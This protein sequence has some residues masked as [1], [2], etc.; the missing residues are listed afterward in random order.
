MPT[1]TYQTA[2]IN[3]FKVTETTEKGDVRFME[4]DG[5]KVQPTNR[6]WTSLCSNFSTMGM[7]LKMFKMFSHSEVFERLALRNGD[8]IQYTMQGDG[9]GANKLLGICKPGKPLANY[10]NVM[11][12]L[13]KYNASEIEYQNGSGSADCGIVQSWHTPRHMQDIKVGGDTLVPKYVL[14]T[15]IDGFGKP[16]I[17]LSLLR[18]VCTNGMIGYSKAFKS[19]LVLGRGQDVMHTLERALDSY[20]NEEG[21]M[22]LKARLESAT[23]S[24]ASVGE[25]QAVFKTVSRMA[26]DFEQQGEGSTWINDLAAREGIT[27]GGD[28]SAVTDGMSLKLQRALTR[29]VGDF[30]IL[31]GLAHTDALSQRQQQSM[32][33]KATVYDLLNFTT[34]AATHYCEKGK[35]KSLH[36]IVG[37]MLTGEYDLEESKREVPTF[38]DWHIADSNEAK[39]FRDDR[40]ELLNN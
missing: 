36:G 13:Q 27:L 24:W 28:G 8:N 25:A 12:T 34:E 21:Y 10:D 1:F 15:P 19:D 32:P 30:S 9:N 17:Y 11:N 16:T 33:S 23:Q 2:P 6:F 26:G 18:Q 4:I 14:E 7:N 5:Q 39:Q 31:Y 40:D 38:A 22:A 29:L 35:S 3:A 20:N 37:T